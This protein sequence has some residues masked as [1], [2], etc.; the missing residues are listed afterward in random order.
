MPLPKQTISWPLTGGID[1]K[2]SPL[3]VVPG[4]FLTLDN[5][6]QERVNEWRTRSGTSHVTADDVPDGNVSMLRTVSLPRGGVLGQAMEAA[7]SPT[8]PSTLIYT[9]STLATRRWARSGV[10]NSSFARPKLWTRRP[11]ATSVAVP[12][13]V[14]HAAGAVVTLSAWWSASENLVRVSLQSKTEGDS[15]T[16]S[17]IVGG[18]I[19]ANTPVRPRCVYNGNG[20]LVLVWVELATGNVKAQSFSGNTGAAIAGPTTL[21]GGAHGTDPYIDAVYYSQG[22]NTNVTVAYRTAGSQIRFLEVN[23]TTLA[24]PT[25]VVLAVNCNTCLSLL[26]DPDASGIRF[27]TTYDTA[28]AALRVLRINAAGAIQTND[29]IAEAVAVEQAGGVAY[30]AGAGW[31]VVYETA[32]A[33]KACK[34]RTAVVSAVVTISGFT[35]GR[36]SLA[37]GAWRSAGVDAM[38]YVIRYRGGQGGGG[39]GGSFVDPQRTYYEMALEFENLSAAISRNYLEAQARMLPFE[40]SSNLANASLAHVQ[41]TAT[42]V[43]ETA[44]IRLLRFDIAAGVEADQWAFDRW[45]VTYLNATNVAATN[46]GD[47]VATGTT[48]YLPDGQLLQTASGEIV[49]GHGGSTVP[50]ISAMTPGVGGAMTPAAQY[51]YLVTEDLWDDAGNIWHGPPSTPQLVTMGGAQTKVDISAWFG[52]HENRSRKRTVKIWRTAANG[53]VFRLVYSV[54]DLCL[55]LIVASFTDLIAD[56]TL[57]QSEIFPADLP[58]GLTPAFSHVALFGNRLW[59]V[60][61]DFPQTVWFSKPLQA[62]LAPEFPG[63]IQR[64][65]RGRHGQPDGDRRAWTTR[66]RSG[67]P[68]RSTSRPATAPT[69]PAP[70]EFPRVRARAVGRRQHRPARRLDGIGSVFRLAARLPP[71]DAQPRD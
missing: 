59:G 26:Q 63:G 31:L 22:G 4:S 45:Q 42:D 23:P 7:G 66:S 17:V 51:Q 43:F 62:G 30:Q 48:A 52:E 25:S 8:P 49:C 32:A 58:T 1:T 53:S 37:T 3:A 12:S 40:A 55:N 19:S 20:T 64:Q 14:S 44:L 24:T 38:H 10:N 68:G 33:I 65:R 46:I 16:E 54:T 61:R 35:G 50:I 39:V 21:A 57:V 11:L 69:T 2:N 9:P 27:V 36:Y 28:G 67:S 13:A 41:Q 70:V 34:K 71:H 56:T 60:D 5:V 15:L 18:L 29:A 47:G 6:R